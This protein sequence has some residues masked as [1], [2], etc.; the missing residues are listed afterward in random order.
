M[1][2]T[3]GAYACAPSKGGMWIRT[4]SVTIALFKSALSALGLRERRQYDTR[5]TYTT[6]CLTAGMSPAFI[7]SPLGHSV[8]MLLSTYAKWLSSTCDCRELETLPVRY[9]LAPRWPRT[10]APTQYIAETPA[11]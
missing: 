8:E 9:E 6:M 10:K 5:H 2:F 7:A 1:T 3:V 11:G 4:S